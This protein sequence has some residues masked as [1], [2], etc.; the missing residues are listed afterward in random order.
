MDLCKADKIVTEDLLETVANLDPEVR[1]N[2]R[3]RVTRPLDLTSGL[4][5]ATD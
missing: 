3:I 1:F 4:G 5:F 2:G